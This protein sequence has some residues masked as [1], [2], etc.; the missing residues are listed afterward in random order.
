[1]GVL[2]SSLLRRGALAALLLLGACATLPTLDPT[3]PLPTHGPL[4]LEGADGRIL[5]PQQSRAILHK[6]QDGAPATDLFR[7]HLALEQAISGTPLTIGNKATLLEDGPNTYRAMLAAIAAARDHINFETYIFDDDAVGQRFAD[8]LIARQREG[9]QVNLIYDS[10]GAIG[11]PKAFFERMRDAGINVLEFNPIDPIGSK[12]VWDPNRRD[13]R[14]L[15]IVDG[16]TGFLGGINISGV[17]SSA[18]FRKRRGRRHA[19][20]PLPWRDTDLRLQGPVVAEL[21]TLFMQTWEQQLGAPLAPRH[22]FPPL[23]ARGP[24]VV[25]AIGS[26]PEQPFSL[27]YATFI[28]AINSAETE[29]LLTNGYFVPDPQLVDAL[30]AAVARGVSVK[31]VL[32]STSDFWMVFRAGQSHYTKLLRGGVRLY[33]LQDA[34]LHSKTA[35]IDGVWSTVGSTNLDWRSFLHNQEVNAVI[36][37]TEFGAQMRAS[38]ERDVAASTEITLEHWEQRPLGPRLKELFGRMWQYWL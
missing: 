3:V 2:P 18:P 23:R 4:R 6:L 9:V 8:A 21:Q 20:H 14:K 36:L 17:Y 33:A 26:S 35:L 13:H 7:R 11:T 16:H 32:P 15:L 31:I 37:G 28:S 25:R 24:D 22:Y 19:Q 1:M 12:V 34:L 30:I 29:I 5:S 27:I 10:I 38:F